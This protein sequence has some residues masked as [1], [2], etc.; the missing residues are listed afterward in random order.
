[1]L[2]K[3]W[4]ASFEVSSFDTDVEVEVVAAAVVVLAVALLVMV[5]SS[6]NNGEERSIDRLELHSSVNQVSILGTIA[7]AAVVVVELLLYRQSWCLRARVP[8]ELDEY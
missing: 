5:A 3:H 6:S 8:G 4:E 1:M 2:Q 7:A